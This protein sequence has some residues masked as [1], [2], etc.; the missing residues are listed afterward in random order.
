MK[1]LL[2]AP[3][4]AGTHY[5]GPGTSAYRLYKENKDE[6]VEVTLVHGSEEQENFPEVFKRQIR[7]CQLRKNSIFSTFYYL[8]NSYKWL[9]KNY[10]E[11]DVFHGITAYVYTFIPALIFK[12]FGKPAFIKVTGIHGGFENNGRISRISGIST[13]RLKKANTLSGYISISSDITA[14]LKRSG[15]EAK[16][17][18]YIPNGVDTKRFRPILCE[19]KIALRKKMEINDVFT[20]C[21]VGGLTKNKRIIEIVKAVHQLKEKGVRIQFLIVGPDRSGQIV[22]NEIENYIKAYDLHDCCLRIHHTTQPEVYFNVSDLFILNSEFEG[23]SNSLLEAMACGLPCVATPASGTVDL[24][25]DDINGCFTDG[26]FD[27]ICEKILVLYNDKQL[28]SNMSNQARKKI[29]ER[30]SVQY[31]LKEHIKL[32][33]DKDNYA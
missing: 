28:V 23:L 6:Q 16:R 1:I 12:A 30:F 27:N 13:L 15:V 25:E 24:I 2:W 8:Y 10:H 19:D 11:Y 7:I 9:Y 5:W 33:E 29:I 26:T 31:I 20:I 4:G 22:E 21:Y 3:F 14:S 18:K 17:I 32:F